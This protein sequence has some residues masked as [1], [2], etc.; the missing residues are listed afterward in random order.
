MYICRVVSVLL[1]GAQRER[2]RESV[3]A[4]AIKWKTSSSSVAVRCVSSTKGDDLANEL[5]VSRIR[6]EFDK[7]SPRSYP[8]H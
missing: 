4:Y 6:S 3:S 7:V 5:W 8:V 2:E 1:G